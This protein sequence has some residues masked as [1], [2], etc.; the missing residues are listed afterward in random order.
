MVLCINK[1]FSFD[2]SKHDYSL[3][4]SVLKK[5][6]NLVGT[7]DYFDSFNPERN[8]GSSVHVPMVDLFFL[9]TF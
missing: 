7:N 2:M 1:H 5:H 8:E 3:G 4:I 6:M 9:S